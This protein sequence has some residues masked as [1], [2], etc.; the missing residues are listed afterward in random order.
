MDQVHGTTP[1]KL[2]LGKKLLHVLCTDSD[3]VTP[4]QGLNLAPAARSERAQDQCL[5][6]SHTVPAG[7]AGEPRRDSKRR[8]RLVE[9]VLFGE[10]ANGL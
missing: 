7:H 10:K 1:V 2:R 6:R 4:N 8:H 5:R 9:A 3:S